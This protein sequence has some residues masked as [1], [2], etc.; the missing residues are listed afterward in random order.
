[1][2]ATAATAA[3]SEPGEYFPHRDHRILNG[4][5][6]VAWSL[7]DAGAE[8][9][10]FCCIP[11][12]HKSSFKLP[13]SVMDDPHSA[14]CVIRPLTPQGSVVLFSEAL[15]HGTSPWMAEHAR[16][17]LLYKYCVSNLTWSN[18]RVRPPEN[19]ELSKR[20]TQLFHEPGDPH[21]YFPSLF[22][23]EA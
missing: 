23:E 15:M 12:S 1:M 22:E 2:P 11:G 18:Q 19:M 20:Q 10:G 21:R 9:G 4:F 7:A 14:S 6:V 16:L 5:V 8:H 13:Q 3:E 17:S